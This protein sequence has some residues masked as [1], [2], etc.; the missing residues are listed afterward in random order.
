V[1]S[2]QRLY[3]P[4]TRL[5]HRYPLASRYY[6]QLFAE[7]LG[8]RLVAAPTVF[9]QL[10]GV[11]LVDDPRAGLT[12]SVPPLLAERVP[13]G[14]ALSLGQADESFTVYDHPQPL[15]FQKVRP[16]NHEELQGLLGL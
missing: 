13:P 10:A 6:Q 4:I 7:Q 8:F 15:V 14:L 2:S 3:A 16:L 11:A 5:S 1:L 9:P 12:L